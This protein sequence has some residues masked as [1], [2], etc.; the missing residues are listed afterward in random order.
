MDV[1]PEAGLPDHLLGKARRHGE[2]VEGHG[3]H[4]GHVGVGLLHRHAV[5][6]PRDALVAEVAEEQLLAVEAEGQVEV[7]VVVEEAQ[8]PRQD[9]DHGARLAVDGQGSADGRRIAAEVALPVAVGED[10]GLGRSGGVVLAGEEAPEIRL[11]AQERQGAVGHLDDRHLLGLGLAGHGGPAVV[12]Q[13][14]V[15]E[16]LVLLPVREVEGG[17]LV[18]PVPAQPGRG[19]PDTDQ[20]V[21]VLEGE[22]LEQHAVDHAEDGD[23]GAQPQGQRENRGEGE[24]GRSPEAPEDVA[25]LLGK[26]VH[27]TSLRR[28]S[29]ARRGEAG[30][31]ALRRDGKGS[32]SEA[33]VV[34]AGSARRSQR[35]CAFPPRRL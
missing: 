32:Y 2:A 22:G 25:E 18:H 4:A 33:L 13:A 11:D 8:A 12:P 6:Q 16:G 27:G 5:A 1:G 9:A 30:L 17:A 34:L 21:G 15:D 35:G 23:G 20:T 26:E 10:H 24:G 28:R 3:D 7:R 19:V 31:P 14:G 29:R